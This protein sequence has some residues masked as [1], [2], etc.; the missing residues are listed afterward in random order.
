MLKTLRT[1]SL[2]ATALALT[3]ALGGCA[4]PSQDSEPSADG[5]DRASAAAV[6]SAYG[7]VTVNG[8]PERIV[9]LDSSL[10]ETLGIL[11][12]EA[13]VLNGEKS[14][15]DDYPWIEYDGEFD[16][17]LYTAGDEI[18][19]EAV[20]A[21]EPDLIL[22]NVWG[23]D[24]QVYEQL[25]LIAPTYAGRYTQEEGGDTSWQENLADIAVLT[26]NDPSLVADAEAEYDAVLAA[27]AA[28]LPGLQGKTF[29]LGVYSSEDQQLWLT[30]YANGPITGLGLTRGTGQ[31]SGKGGDVAATAK[32]ISL[33]NIDQLDADVVF[34]VMIEAYDPEGKFQ[35]AFEKDPRVPELPAAKNGTLVELLGSHWYAVNPSTPASV[36]WWLEQLMPQL[37]A[38]ALNQ[39]GQ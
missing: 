12:E 21:W 10:L 29:Q 35:A 39:S 2:I 28:K 32:K 17:K 13:V 23:I 22:G 26:G 36:E 15:L 24:E 16:A 5:G 37:E 30:E 33:E 19:P 14:D 27:S 1:T 3:I 6:E 18:S 4:G 31:P 9:V 34:V 38:S 11:G 8:E 20:A 25:S 7:T